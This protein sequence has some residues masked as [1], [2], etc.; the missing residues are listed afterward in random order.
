MAILTAESG[1]LT[2]PLVCTLIRPAAPFLASELERLVAAFGMQISV[3]GRDDFNVWI[4]TDVPPANIPLQP[5][6]VVA[7][8]QV[9]K[10][11]TLKDLFRKVPGQSGSV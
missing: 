6:A 11:P 9:Q 1:P 8:A 2:I 4:S 7:A 3:A 10:R 5:P